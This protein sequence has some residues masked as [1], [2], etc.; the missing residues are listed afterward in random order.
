MIFKS[1]MVEAILS[2]RKVVTRRPVKYRRDGT[3]ELNNCRYEVGGGP[4]GTYSLQGPPAKGSKARAKTVEGYR[5]RVTRVLPEI[6]ASI[7]DAEAHLEGF[8]DRPAFVAYWK[9][10]YGR[11]DSTQL[12]HRI[13]FE[14]VPELEN[15][16]REVE[17][18]A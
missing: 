13:E 11:F 9:K 14:L 6:I 10:L 4:D 16:E 7:N 5:L 12:V 1:E 8:R 18:A 3:A 17:A 2:G 15:P